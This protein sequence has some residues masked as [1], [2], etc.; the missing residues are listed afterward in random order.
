[1]LALE[2]R[3]GGRWLGPPLPPALSALPIGMWT[4]VMVL[5]ATDRDPAPRRGIDAAGMLSA[6]GILA[7]GATALTGLSDWTVSNDQDRRVGLFHGLLNTAAPGLQGASLGTRMP[8][9]R[10]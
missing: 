8:A 10:P 1:M 5:D 4:G 7:A 3:H 6:A 2:L 9:H